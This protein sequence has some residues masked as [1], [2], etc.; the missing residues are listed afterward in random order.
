MNGRFLEE[1]CKAELFE[2]SPLNA[3]DLVAWRNSIN[4]FKK[5]EK[6]AFENNK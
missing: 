4:M 2:I 5:I 3:N 6:I 1:N